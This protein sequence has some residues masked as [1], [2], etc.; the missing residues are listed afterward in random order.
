MSKIKHFYHSIPVKGKSKHATSQRKILHPVAKKLTKHCMHLLVIKVL[1][2]LVSP[3]WIPRDCA[4]L[5]EALPFLTPLI[6]CNHIDILEF[7]V[8]GGFI[9]YT[10]VA[11]YRKRSR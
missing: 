9:V 2:M 1:I 4:L 7:V 11:F 6:G 8:A 5:K 3:D 10:V